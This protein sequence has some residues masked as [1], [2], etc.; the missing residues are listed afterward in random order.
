VQVNH[1]QILD[2][3]FRVCGVPSDKFRSI[4]SSVDKLD[5]LPWEE[6]KQEMVNEKGLDDAA[7]DRIGEYVKLSG[8]WLYEWLN[9]LLLYYKW[10]E[11][12]FQCS[13]DWESV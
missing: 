5:K 6:V 4:C 8:T 2:G 12:I 7:A 10:I 3:M 13:T 11:S 9:V 1:R